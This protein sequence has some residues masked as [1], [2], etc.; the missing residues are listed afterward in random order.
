VW[1]PD[2]RRAANRSGLRYPSDLTDAEW[3]ILE[4]MIPPA[5]H[6]GRKRSVNVREVLN[7]IFYVLWTGCQ[8]KALPKDLPPKSTVHD[9]LELWNWDGTLERIHHALY[10]AVREQ[11][12]H[13]ASPTAAIIDSQTAKGAQKGG[14]SLDPAGY[15]AGKKIKGRKRHILVDTLGLLLSVVVHPAD[16]QD[17]DGACHLLRRTRRMFPFIERIFA[18]GGYAGPKMAL[19]ARRTGT[20]RLQIVK[21]SDVAGFEVLPKRWIVERTFGW[22]GRYRRL[23]KDYEALTDSS[24]SMIYLAMIHLM[25][26]RLR[27]AG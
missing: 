1:T 9:Y 27:P 18:D 12:G 2:H 15:D 10:V 17:R 14:A 7:G 8:W 20:W 16:V 22:F 4:P 19:A 6:G 3:A 5:R 24:E 13:E 21:R 23:S 26:R 11:E 25:V